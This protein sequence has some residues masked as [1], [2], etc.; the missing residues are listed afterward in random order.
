MPPR[1]VDEWLESIKYG[2]GR[3]YVSFFDELGVEDEDDLRRMKDARVEELRRLLERSGIKPVQMDY[4]TDAVDE[5]RG[6]G[7]GVVIFLK[8]KPKG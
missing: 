7:R 5:V 6:A 2:Y 3:R 8:I 4:L 1:S